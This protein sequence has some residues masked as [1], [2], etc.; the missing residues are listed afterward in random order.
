MNKKSIIV[1]IIILIIVA[2]F[3]VDIK[4]DQKKQV[5]V[6]GLFNLVG[7]A[8]FAGEPSR[9]GF[10]M[11]V[12]D[13]GLSEELLKTVIEDAGSDLKQAVSGATKLIQINKAVVVVG[14][15]W[16]E[17]GEVVSPVAVANKVPFISPWIV[18]EAPF[19]KPPYYWSASPSY[20]SEHATLANYL[21]KNKLIRISVVYSNNAWSYVDLKMFKEEISKYPELQIISEQGLDQSVKDFRT[22]ITKIKLDKP[23][24]V[25]SAIAEDEGYGAFLAQARQIGVTVPFSTFSSRATSSVLKDRYKSLLS[26]QIFAESVPAERTVE[27]EEK[28]EK[29]FGRKVGAISAAA[30]YDMTTIV[31]KAIKEGART[32]EDIIEFLNNMEPYEGYSGLI[33][34]DENGRLPLRKAVVKKYNSQGLAEEIK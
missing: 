14:P 21:S 9:D 29:R 12:E 34:Y 2:L 33:D 18:A 26:G 31:L 10:L 32:S 17:F 4:Q 15:E 23:D 27:F 1:G 16:T 24:I 6:G 20:R 3:I 19:V 11:A 25:Y 7:Y 28:Y 13:A 22:V 30:T 5:V 8:S